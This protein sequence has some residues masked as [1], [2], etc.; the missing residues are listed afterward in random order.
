MRK[1]L[2]IWP[3][4]A[5]VIL[6]AIGL[7]IRL[8]VEQSVK[9]SLAA[10]LETMLTVDVEALQTW[11]QAQ[12]SNATVLA[13]NPQVAELIEQLVTEASSPDVTDNA[14]VTSPRL[15]ELR[16]VLKPWL[17]AYNYHGFVVVTRESRILASELDDPIGKSSLPIQPGLLEQVFRM[18]PV[19]TRP[20]ESALLLEDKDGHTRAGMATMFAVAPVLDRQGRTIAAFGARI[21]PDEDFTRILSIARAGGTGETYAFDGRGVMLSQSRFD[22]QLKHIGLLPDREGTSSI[23][24][25]QVRDPLVNMVQGRR[26]AVHRAEQALTRMATSAVTGGSGVDVAGYRDYRGVPV[27]GAWTWLSDYGFGVATELDVA[28]AYRPLYILR[29]SFWTLFALLACSAFAIFIFTVVVARLNRVARQAALD[30]QQ[31]GQYSLDK[32]IGAG[33]MGVVYQGHH[34]MLRRPTAIKLLD[35]DKTTAAAIARFEREVQLT[36]QLNH[37]NTIAIFDYGRTP[38]GI[39]Y[40]AMEFLDGVTLEDLVERHGAQPEGRVIHILQQICGSL[41]EAHGIGLIHRDIKPANIILNRRGGLF[42]FVKLLDFG[43]VKAIDA[44]RQATLTAADAM[45]G[46]PMYMSP[47]AIENTELVDARSDLYAVGGLAYFLLTGNTVF[48]AT[49][50]VEICRQQVQEE[51]RAPSDRLGREVDLDLEA[52]ILKC[53]AKSPQDRP[54]SAEE[55][56]ETLSQCESSGSWTQRNA[57]DWWERTD[58][59]QQLKQTQLTADTRGHAP[60]IL[61][62]PS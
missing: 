15:H 3:V 49:S 55:L 46:T 32:K 42:D 26:P 8:V 25:I 9:D 50:V 10:N 45:T 39:F 27:V 14:L 30:A 6:S 5:A 33:G 56:S 57:A 18:T 60:T 19:V 40:Y 24:N 38:E 21:R 4:I 35:L 58:R 1:Q 31:L 51:P 53:L 59:S 47:E 20:F 17:A 29:W 28:E 22:D 41:C 16:Q 12:K 11:L 36:S 44:K 13:G 61:S 52:I 62:D 2:W 43:L 34:Q 37:P 48:E 23:L 7:T 54:Q